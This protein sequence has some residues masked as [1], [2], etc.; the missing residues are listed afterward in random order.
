ME[1]RSKSRFLSEFKEFIS[2]GN[3]V[4]M[5]V[6]IIVGSAFTAIVNSLVKD[7]IMPFVGFL[8]GGINFTDLKWVIVSATDTSAEVAI[9]YGAL[10][11]AVLNFLIIAFVVFCMVRMLNLF[12]RKKE[13]AE[14]KSGEKP[15]A[16]S[17]ELA[18][19][20]Q[21]YALMAATAE[22]TPLPEDGAQ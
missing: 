9:G 1:K 22:S 11:Q 21:I 6:G 7:V 19:L 17:E 14:E 8:I 2:R 10:L 12:R 5:A 3:V 16:P 18:V 4:D 20:R 13:A 15:A